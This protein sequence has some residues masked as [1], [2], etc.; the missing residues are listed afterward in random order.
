MR[1]KDG[2]TFADVLILVALVLLVVAL[3][4]P[5]F[6]RH[7]ELSDEEIVGDNVTTNVLPVKPAAPAP[8]LPAGRW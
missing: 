7:T 8:W 3:A 2:L 1:G 4:I 6:R 5:F